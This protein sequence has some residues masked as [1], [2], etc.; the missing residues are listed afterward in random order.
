MVGEKEEYYL[1]KISEYHTVNSQLLEKAE[2]SMKPGNI[3]KTDID[4]YRIALE[5]SKKRRDSCKTEKDLQYELEI[6]SLLNFTIVI[7]F[8]RYL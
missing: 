7:R 5:D 3:E 8:A 6:Q 2:K 1:K 4:L